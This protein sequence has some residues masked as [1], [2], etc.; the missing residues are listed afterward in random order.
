MYVTARQ[1]GSLAADQ[2]F[3]DTLDRLCKVCDDA[4]ENYVIEQVLRPLGRAIS[5][6]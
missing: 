4:I 2:T 1:Y 6:Q 5:L 3:V